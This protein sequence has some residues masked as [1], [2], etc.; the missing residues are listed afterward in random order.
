MSAIKREERL[1]QK[2][3]WFTAQEQTIQI[4]SAMLVRMMVY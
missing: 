3:L 2:E 1:H 4:E